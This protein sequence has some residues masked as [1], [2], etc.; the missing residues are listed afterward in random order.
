MDNPRIQLVVSQGIVVGI[1]PALLLTVQ[2]G[3]LMACT[4]YY[5]W[6]VIG[7]AIL[8]AFINLGFLTKYTV[9]SEIQRLFWTTQQRRSL[10]QIMMSVTVVA[11][12]VLLAVL[13]SSTKPGPAR[14]ASVAS[15]AAGLAY[16]TCLLVQDLLLNRQY[17]L[18]TVQVVPSGADYVLNSVP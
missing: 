18:T 13:C 1:V 9:L 10:T 4:P 16:G 17:K 11:V 6:S 15:G 12:L 3:A 2:A 8:C 5:I 7:V 14:N